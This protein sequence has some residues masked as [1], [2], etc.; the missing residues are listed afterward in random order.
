[1][2]EPMQKRQ[3]LRTPG[4]EGG[5]FCIRGGEKG[6]SFPSIQQT[7]GGTSWFPYRCFSSRKWKVSEMGDTLPGLFCDEEEFPSPDGSVRTVSGSIPGNAK[8]GSLDFIFGPTGQHVGQ[9]MLDA[10][11]GSVELFG[12]AGAGVVGMQIADGCGRPNI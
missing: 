5:K 10:E 11:E 8:A 1:M 9:M 4:T 2:K 7:E 6:L 12:H 3:L